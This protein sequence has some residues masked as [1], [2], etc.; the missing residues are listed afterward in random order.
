MTLQIF[1]NWF[2]NH[3]VTEV[4]GYC[5][6]KGL[7]FKVLLLLGNALGHLAHLDDFNPNVK[8]VYLPSNTTSLF[9]PMNQGFI[10]SFKA[11]Y[12]LRTFVI[13]FRATEKD[14]DLTQELLKILQKPCCKKNISVK[15]M[16]LNGVH[17]KCVPSL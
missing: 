4:E 17:K 11:F 3:F 13:A 5:A 12:L 6:S 2:T 16:N 14:K 1:D 8:V 7:P 9:Q 15:L 10:A